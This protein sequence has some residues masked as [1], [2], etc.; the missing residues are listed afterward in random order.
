MDLY[1]FLTT[2]DEFYYPP[3]F[4][5][6]EV[7][8]KLLSA[9]THMNVNNILFDTNS[10]S[11]VIDRSTSSSASHFILDYIK[12][13]YK[14]LDRVIIVGIVSRLI[15]TYIELVSYKIKDNDRSLIDLQI[16]EALYL[17]NFQ[18]DYLIHNNYYI[19][20]ILLEITTYYLERTQN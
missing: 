3:Y 16:N 18:R 14:V 7:N 4:L 1:Y 2:L 20:I 19:N 8:I 9:A 6:L 13:T 17:K 12:N 11:L 5:P 15:V 10:H